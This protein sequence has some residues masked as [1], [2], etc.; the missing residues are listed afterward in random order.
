M[1]VIKTQSL[2]LVVALGALL[3]GTALL[4]GCNPTDETNVEPPAPAESMPPETTPPPT[5]TPPTDPNAPD[6][7][8]P[9][10]ANPNAPQTTPSETPPPPAD[11][12]TPPNG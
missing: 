9:P 3:S 1:K 6:P 11:G 5:D 12:G 10:P 2:S 4:S 7:N 8:T